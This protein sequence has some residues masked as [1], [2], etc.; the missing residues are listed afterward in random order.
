MKEYGKTGKKGQSAL[1][2]GMIRNTGSKYLKL[3]KLPS[4]LKQPRTWR[5]RPDPFE[6]DWPEITERLR[7]APELEAK[8][9]FE[10]LLSRYPDRYDPGQVR[11]FQRR[12]KQ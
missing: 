9:L 5:T 4:E 6:E 2:S 12:L 10:Y 8:A 7:D 3:G 1:R 11:T